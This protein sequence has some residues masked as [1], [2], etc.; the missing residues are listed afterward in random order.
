MEKKKK[1]RPGGATVARLTPDQKVACSN[2]VRVTA[3]FFFS[4]GFYRLVFY[5]D[6]FEQRR[7]ADTFGISLLTA[8]RIKILPNKL[9]NCAMFQTFQPYVPS[10]KE[11]P[12]AFLLFLSQMH[13]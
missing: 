4:P 8:P 5:Q 1:V 3:F 12:H 10:E 9:C 2:H 13:G 7:G 6:F 11:F